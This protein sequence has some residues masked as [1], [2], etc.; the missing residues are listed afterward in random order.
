VS[1]SGL[2][3]RNLFTSGAAAGAAVAAA[4]AEAAADPLFAG[5]RPDLPLTTWAAAGGPA[6]A[7]G[8]SSGL[9]TP[10]PTVY[11]VNRIT[12]G[13]QAADLARA[14]QL[15]WDGFIEEQLNPEQIDDSALDAA[16]GAF[17]TLSMR[18]N[19]LLAM[20]KKTVSEALTAATILRAI[21]SKRQLLELMVDFWTNHFN[22]FGHEKLDFWLKTVDDRAVVRAHAL[23]NFGDLLRASAASPAMLSYLD[24]ASNTKRGPN[25]N[26]AREMMELHTLGLNGGQTQQDVEEVARCFTGWTIQPTG[27]DRGSFRYN[28]ATHDD[29]AHLFLGQTIPAGLGIE[30]GLQV[31]AIC[32]THPATAAHVAGKLCVRFVADSPSPALVSAAAATFT[33]TGGDIRQ[34]MRTILGSAD[35][36]AASDQ[37][38][39][40]PFE[41]AV[42]AVRALDA[43]LGDGGLTSLAGALR[44][45]GQLPFNWQPPNGYPDSN[46]AWANTNGMLSR[47]NLGLALGANALAG[48]TADLTVAPG[49]TAAQI[50]DHFAGRLLSRPLLAADRGK[51]I[52][53]V[54]AEGQAKT[55]VPG[56]VALILDSPY[57][58]WR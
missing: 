53:W 33:A 47:W 45:M 25:E 10:D 23:G 9:P 22:V 52:A 1:E 40:R 16:L 41:A 4:L 8:G 12:F 13:Q 55:K 6:A 56:L 32:A 20:D 37:K 26:Y 11:L 17:P 30:Q 54:A 44:L 46:A 49:Q 34:V 21:Y 35:F 29:S 31:L 48:V 39:R 14:A 57:F 24:N 2:S 58:Q 28:P 18:P 27:N 51:L 42:A 38:L 50:V 19:R 3:R 5:V 7:P 43:Q 15:G 36:A